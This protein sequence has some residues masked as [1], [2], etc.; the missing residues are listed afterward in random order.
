MSE[1]GLYGKQVKDLSYQSHCTVLQAVLPLTSPA[2]VMCDLIGICRHENEFM[3][4]DANL[5]ENR[6]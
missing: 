2:R 5:W 1:Y 3:F 6:A 4:T